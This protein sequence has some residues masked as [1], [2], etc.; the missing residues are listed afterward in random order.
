M[1][2]LTWVHAR[3]ARDRW[4]EEQAILFE[5]LR[6]V[7]ATFEQL[8]SSWRGKEPSSDIP[9]L[10]RK[11]FRAYA[12]KTAAIFQS[13]AKEARIQLAL[14]EEH[15]G[16]EADLFSAEEEPFTSIRISSDAVL[17]GVMGT[18]GEEIY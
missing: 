8:E 6:R 2:R 1:L 15:R 16:R 3:S 7:L 9:L 11:G 12:L 13:L 4:W 18:K 17:A 14:V 10:V 5:E